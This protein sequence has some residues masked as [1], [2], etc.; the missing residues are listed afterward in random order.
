[1]QITYA[2]RGDHEGGYGDDE[3]GVGCDDDDASWGGVAE[4]LA[5]YRKPAVSN[6]HFGPTSLH[7]SEPP[8]AAAPADSTFPYLGL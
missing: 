8:S 6:L 5:R 4:A 3:D 1:M 2:L 7:F